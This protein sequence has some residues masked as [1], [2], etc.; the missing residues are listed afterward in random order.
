MSSF[1]KGNWRG[2]SGGERGRVEGRGAQA[3]LPVV[4]YGFP[5]FS[6]SEKRRKTA[7]LQARFALQTSAFISS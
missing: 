4:I 6:M 3:L 2:G 1:H 7:A 5:L